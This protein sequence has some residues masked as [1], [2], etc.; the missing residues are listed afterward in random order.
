VPLG[1]EAGHLDALHVDEPPVG[2]QRR[3]LIRG[4]AAFHRD[5]ER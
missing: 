4:L 1:L 3:D 5:D 2:G